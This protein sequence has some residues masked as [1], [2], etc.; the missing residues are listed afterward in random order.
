[1]KL[2]MNE[3]DIRRFWLLVRAIDTESKVLSIWNPQIPQNLDFQ[4][5]L[6]DLPRKS[7]KSDNPYWPFKGI[8]IGPSKGSHPREPRQAS[9]KAADNK[10]GWG[11]TL[12]QKAGYLIAIRTF[13]GF[14]SNP[15]KIYFSYDFRGSG[16]V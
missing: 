14:R 16:G 12:V 7:R 13:S 6:L 15:F 4:F 10:P 11:G 3:V 2:D 5:V 8:P 9:L 1:M